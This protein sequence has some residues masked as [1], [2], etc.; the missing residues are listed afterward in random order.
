MLFHS[1][2]NSLFSTWSGKQSKVK[3]HIDD[4]F[5]KKSLNQLYRHIWKSSIFQWSE[6]LCTISLATCCYISNS[7]LKCII[8]SVILCSCSTFIDTTMKT[9]IPTFCEIRSFRRR[10]FHSENFRRPFVEC[11]SSKAKPS[12]S[13]LLYL[14]MSAIENMAEKLETFGSLKPES[15]DLLRSVPS[16]FDFRAPPSA[17]PETLL[18]KG[19]E[20]YSCR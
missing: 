4:V 17:L 5:S 2:P 9:E 11:W 6:D 13:C 18:R 8:N 14:Q 1:L 16:M 20:R 7:F 12:P 10:L 15:G 3:I 19:K